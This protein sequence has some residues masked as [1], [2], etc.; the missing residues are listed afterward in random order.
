[1]SY[2]SIY[3]KE[4]KKRTKHNPLSDKY[5]YSRLP[6]RKFDIIYADPP[7]DYNGKLQFDNTRLFVSGATLKYPPMK[8]ADMMKIPIQKIAAD[9]CLLFLWTTSPHLSQAITLGESWGFQYKT[10][11]FVWN[12]QIH[13]PGHYTLSSCELCLVFKR[14]RIPTPRGAR[15]IRQLVSSPR[16]KHSEKPIQVMQAIHKMFP[17]QSKIEIFANKRYPGW[18]SWGLDLL[19]KSK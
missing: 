13:N 8:T 12:K 9:D 16:G 5:L 17:K 2:Y 10:V 14:G 18:S 11:A 6:R 19:L 15:N 1:M 7:Y 3:D 4:V